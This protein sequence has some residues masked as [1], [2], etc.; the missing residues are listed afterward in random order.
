[1]KTFGY[2]I[3]IVL[4]DISKGQNFVHVA[5]RAYQKLK[6]TNSQWAC[7]MKSWQKK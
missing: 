6:S 4:G 7:N 1:M 2:E 3:T 5:E